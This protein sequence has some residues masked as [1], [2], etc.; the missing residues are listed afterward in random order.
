MSTTET[1]PVKPIT[2]E[3]NISFSSNSVQIGQTALK[4]SNEFQYQSISKSAVASIVF[5]IL[6]L[7][8]YLSQIFVVLPIL[9]IGFGVVAL[10][11][12]RRYPD[13]LVG[14]LPAKIGLIT[15][16]VI[17]VTALGMHSYIYATEVPE[18]YQ[19]ITFWDL[20]DNPKVTSIPFSEKAKEFDGEKVFLKGYVRPG[21]GRKTGLKEFILVGDF[22]DCCFG[23][24]PDPTE[25]VAIDI[26][27]D[28]TVDSTLSLRRIG[29]VF[30]LNPASIPINEEG[31]PNIYY[32]IEAD[33]IR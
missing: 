5:T 20:R 4:P 19:R 28:E 7:T 33:Y 1:K 16:G 6:G 32:T 18:G 12:I 21:T 13:E 15:S 14:S 23:G 25:I 9:G 2:N 24:N 26:K 17:F 22:G 10:A 8:A 30:K 27:I 3:S 29:G 11:S 31:L